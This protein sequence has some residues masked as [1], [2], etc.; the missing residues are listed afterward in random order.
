LTEQNRRDNARAEAALGDDA[1]AAASALLAA[2]LPNDAI[3]RAYYAAFHYARALLL[4]KGLEPKSHRGVF[5]LLTQH[6]EHA[7]GLSRASISALARL[8][9]FRGLADYDSRARLGAD[10]AQDEVESA[11]AFVE[12][13]ASLL[14]REGVLT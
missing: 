1:L 14:R 5:A 7:D 2:G 9:T 4:V 6:W 12:A 8:Q 10:R 3:S 13:A 11:R